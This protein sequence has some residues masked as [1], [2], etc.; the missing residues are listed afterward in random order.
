MGAGGIDL[1]RVIRAVP[2][3]SPTSML[4]AAIDSVSSAEAAPLT[5]SSLSFLRSPR[6]DGF[7][8]SVAQ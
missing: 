7:R 1:S 6:R 8:T 4:L 2:A 3:L 5:H